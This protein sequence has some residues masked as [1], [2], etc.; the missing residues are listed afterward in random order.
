M[1]K[2][3][4]AGRMR[5]SRFLPVA[6]NVCSVPATRFRVSY[7]TRAW[8]KAWCSE[9]A[10]SL[11]AAQRGC[12]RE[13][14]FSQAAD[15]PRKYTCWFLASRRFVRP[16]PQKSNVV[17]GCRSDSLLSQGDPRHQS[18][19]ILRPIAMNS[20]STHSR[21]LLVR[22]GCAVAGAMLLL[23]GCGVVWDSGGER[24]ALGIGYI[25]WPLPATNQAT[26]VQG[27]DLI[28]AA[29][30]AT[31][32]DI[33]VVVGYSSERSVKLDKDQVVTLDCLKCDLAGAHPSVAAVR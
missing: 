12:N 30:L 7:S 1:E 15:A 22:R 16:E 19:R 11:A 33:G 23:S 27:V 10:L 21:W 2:L 24:H 8:S 17:G 31:Q 14:T 26:V 25:A 32:N 9:R 28:G 3:D 5:P 13:G 20:R 29:V 18:A 4:A 6:S